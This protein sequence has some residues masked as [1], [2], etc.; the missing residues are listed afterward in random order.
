MKGLHVCVL[1]CTA[2]CPHGHPCVIFGGAEH[3]MSR[4]KPRHIA[5]DGEQMHEWT[6]KAGK[7][8]LSPYTDEEGG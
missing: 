2:D 6:G 8:T 5:D 3:P 1:G 7:C 4:G